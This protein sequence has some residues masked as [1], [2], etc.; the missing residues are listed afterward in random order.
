MQTADITVSRTSECLEA[1]DAEKCCFV[2]PVEKENINGSEGP[3]NGSK[4]DDDAQNSTLEEVLVD[5]DN[6]DALGQSCRLTD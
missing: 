1:C 4:D 6:N 3:L 5:N 2:D